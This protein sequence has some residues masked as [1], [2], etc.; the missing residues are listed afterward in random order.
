MKKAIAYLVAQW[1]MLIS[2]AVVVVVGAGIAYTV[3]TN[4]KA[5]EELLTVEPARFLQE[6]SISGKVVAGQEVDLGFAQGG[7]VERVTVAVGDRVN[8]G[9]V[10]AEVENDDIVALVA[11]REATLEAEQ[12]VLASLKSGTRPEEVAIA[13]AD[14]RAKEAA[15]RQAAQAIVDEIQDAYT[16]VDDA[17][18]VQVDQFMTNG[19]SAP[20]VSFTIPSSQ[21]ELSLENGRREMESVLDDWAQDVASISAQSDLTVALRISKERLSKVSGFLLIANSAV[22]QGG[23]NGTVTQ[24]ELDSYAVDVGL[25]R[26]SVN[27]ATGALT[28][29][30]TAWINAGTAVTSSEKNLTLKRAGATAD[31]IRAQEAR[32]LAARASVDDARAQLRKT[33]IL[34]PF[35]GVVTVVDAKVGA[36]AQANA[37]SVSLQSTGDYSIESYVPEI[38]IALLAPLDTAR[39]TLDAYGTETVFLATLT[40]IDPAETIKDGVS[41]YRA[42]FNF[43]EVDARVKA[44]MTANVIVVTDDRAGVIQIPQRIVTSRDGAKYVQLKVGESYVERVVETGGVSS[45]GNIEIVSGLSVGEQV[46]L[47]R[48]D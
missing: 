18:R 38:N 16:T 10:L 32:I 13:E 11:Q 5:K 41:T 2:V 36:V 9:D 28:T 17:V 35:R 30:E 26:S 3:Y 29:A 39:V 31:D 22:N 21:T 15:L 34:A 44:G 7:R 14:V 6:V 4:G 19:G 47:V 45:G 40:S 48:G 12:A 43:T 24:A 23:A 37:S 27:A 33:R 8:A 1:A 20:Q 42:L 25:A 46:V